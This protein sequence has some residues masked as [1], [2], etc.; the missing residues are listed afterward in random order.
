MEVF[1]AAAVSTVPKS[2]LRVYG[3]TFVLERLSDISTL[4]LSCVPRDVINNSFSE[5]SFQQRFQQRFQRWTVR[6]SFIILFHSFGD[7]L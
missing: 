1:P 6:E 2:T 5:V 4:R 3:R 7:H